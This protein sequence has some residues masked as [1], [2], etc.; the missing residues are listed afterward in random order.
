M[1]QG[2]ED[3]SFLGQNTAGVIVEG[4]QN[5]DVL[6]DIVG[7]SICRHN[8]FVAKWTVGYSEYEISIVFSARRDC[9]G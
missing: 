3:G 7:I 9:N 4:S 1:Q 6:E 8:K 5:V 2:Q